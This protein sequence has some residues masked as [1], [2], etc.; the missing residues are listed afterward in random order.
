[1]AES[2]QSLV[3]RVHGMTCPGA[4]AN[5]KPVQKICPV[6]RSNAAAESASEE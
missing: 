5:F 2:D 1:M 3:Q 4:F 6:C